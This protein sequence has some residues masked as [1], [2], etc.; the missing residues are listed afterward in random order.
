[1]LIFTFV[2]NLFLPKG[3]EDIA[4]REAKLFCQ[5]SARGWKISFIIKK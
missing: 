5:G 3:L 1:M 2:K 4:I